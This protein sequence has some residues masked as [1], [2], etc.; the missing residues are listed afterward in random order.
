MH[1][2]ARLLGFDLDIDMPHELNAVVYTNFIEMTATRDA[3]ASPEK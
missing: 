3:C 1:G 2:G